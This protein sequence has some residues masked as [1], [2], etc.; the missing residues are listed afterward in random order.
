MSA[1]KPT[2]R[3][4]LR[5]AGI[6]VASLSGAAA[7]N[8]GAAAATAAQDDAKESAKRLRI[9]LPT[10][11]FKHYDLDQT[12]AMAKRVAVPNLCLRSNLLPLES[13]DRQIRAVVEKVEQS[14]LQLYG[15]GVI[16]MRDEASVHR[17]FDYARTAGF[18][19]ISASPQP[20]LLPLVERKVREF[21]IRVAIHNHGPEDRHY[22]TPAAIHEKTGDLDPRIGICHDTGHTL[23][24][25]VDPTAATRKTADRT[26]DIHLKDVDARTGKGHSTELGR[27]IM[28]I[29][30]FL[31]MLLEIRYRGVVGIEYEKDMKD[32]LPGLAESAGFVR[33][34]LAAL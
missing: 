19:L 6:G 11:M 26:L 8:R 22:P 1:E 13:D 16:Y 28:D 5:A 24:A 7:A 10:Y 4:F 17:A 20:D 29:P 21:D 9:G 18:S 2:R 33:G 31:R 15:G 12:I 27:G 14:G 32:L 23:R 30:R 25:G 3:S 34:V